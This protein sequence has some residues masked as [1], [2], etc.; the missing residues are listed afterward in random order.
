MKLSLAR[1]LLQLA[2]LISRGLLVCL[3]AAHTLGSCPLDVDDPKQRRHSCT[4]LD[5]SR[6]YKPQTNLAYLKRQIYLVVTDQPDN[7]QVVLT[8]AFYHR[9]HD[10]SLGDAG[11]PPFQQEPGTRSRRWQHS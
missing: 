11:F 4:I 2:S 3:P 7:E 5:L 6:T 10:L 1:I 9:N 8:K